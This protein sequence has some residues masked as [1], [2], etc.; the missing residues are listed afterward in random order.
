VFVLCSLDCLEIPGFGSTSHLPQ[1]RCVV[2]S[3]YPRGLVKFS[4]N[5]GQ[6]G[7]PR[8]FGVMG[9]HRDRHV[10]FQKGGEAVE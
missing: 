7:G 6:V 3:G 2:L 1:C 9:R 5:D 10:F 4:T 8:G